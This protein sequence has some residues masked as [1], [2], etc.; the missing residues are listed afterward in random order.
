MA[1]SQ[2]HLSLLVK[3]FTVLG[4]YHDELRYADS[5]RC[6]RQTSSAASGWVS[7]T[8]QPSRGELRYRTAC[9]SDMQG[10]GFLLMVKG[11]PGDGRLSR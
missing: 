10:V 9:S 5:H 3:L 4:N 2:Q 7:V 6:E 11:A 8:G 1:L